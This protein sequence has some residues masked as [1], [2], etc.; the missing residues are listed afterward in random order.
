MFDVQDLDQALLQHDVPLASALLKAIPSEDGTDAGPWRFKGIASDEEAD[1]SGDTILRKSIDLSYAKAKGFV[2]W[3]HSR[4]PED[5]LGFLTKCIL[6]TPAEVE[7]I[8]DSF[9]TPLSKTASVYIEGELYK[10]IPRAANVHEM[11]KSTPQSGTGGL[12]LSLDGVVAR[13]KQS[14][15]IVRAFVRGVAVTPQPQHP[16]TLFKLKKSLQ[17]YEMMDPSGAML[18]AD[19]ISQ[20]AKEVAK[21]ITQGQLVKS[22]PKTLSHDEAII[23]VLRQKPKWTYAVAE[24]FV[25]WHE[26]TKTGG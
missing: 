5:Q 19:L 10:G 24:Q 25:T 12:G 18:P 16:K 9:E 20:L 2:N 6:L 21:E 4:A 11:L 13:D 8:Q 1:V 22:L 26:Q 23:F 14:R 7:R 15:G 3:D 17:A